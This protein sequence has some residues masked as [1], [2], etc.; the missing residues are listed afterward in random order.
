MKHRE[1]VFS[2]C[3]IAVGVGLAVGCGDMSSP[4]EPSPPL[5][6]NLSASQS[7]AAASV[8]P[9]PPLTSNLSASQSTAAASENIGL[10]VSAPTPVEPVGE[11]EIDGFAPLLVALHATGEFVDEDFEYE[12]SIHTTAS[13]SSIEKGNGTS[14]GAGLTSYQVR[15]RLGLETNYRWRIRAFFEK[16]FGPWSDYVS[17]KTAPVRFGTPLQLVSPA[18]GS[19]VDNR[20][21]FVV[22]SGEVEGVADRIVIQIRLAPEGSTL[23]DVNI[24]GEAVVGQAG[25]ETSVSLRD[26]YRLMSGM[27]YV[28]QAKAVVHTASSRVFSTPWS[29]QASFKTAVYRL[30][31]PQ[32]TAPVGVEVGTRP[33]FVVRSGAVEGDVGRRVIRV[34]VALNDDFSNT[35]F[36]EAEIRGGRGRETRIRLRETLQ[37]EMSYFWRARAVAANAPYGPVVSP[38][39]V[40]A[41]FMTRAGTSLGPVRSPPPNLLHVI[42]RV[43]AKHPGAV[44]AAHS[45]GSGGDLTGADDP[46]F[47]F[48]FLTIEALR[49][50]N[51]GRWGATFWTNP[52]SLAR[53]SKDRVGYYL[54]DGDPN[55]STNMA[56]IEFFVWRDGSLAWFDATRSIKRNYPRARGEWRDLPK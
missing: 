3:A 45:A 8:E 50:E 10:K 51:G 25:K 30:G 36:G 29:K 27:S 1:W 18:D 5:T 42:Q 40:T 22:R 48:L 52:G 16:A 14:H 41:R 15:N 21:V 19:V 33:V 46:G 24:V 56:V 7:T 28:W 4:V 20:P 44:K 23:T 55:G 13:G 43:A 34:E 54:G 26:D 37:P 11:V 31:A 32:P 2:V 17:F 12:F 38:W 6:S 35:I 9:S 39:S 49:E 47:Q 53:H